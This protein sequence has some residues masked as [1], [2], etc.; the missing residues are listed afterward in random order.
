MI[1]CQVAT[2][3]LLLGFAGAVGV[4]VVLF[5]RMRWPTPRAKRDGSAALG[6][7]SIPPRRCVRA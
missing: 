3:L 6:D 5:G 4:A 7:A 2:L 1:L